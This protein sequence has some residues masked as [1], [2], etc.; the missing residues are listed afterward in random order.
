MK[1]FLAIILL[2]ISMQ[3]AAQAENRQSSL[4]CMQ[5][6][7]IVDS[8]FSY[9]S[10]GKTKQQM[11]APLPSKDVLAGYP[12]SMSAQRLLGEQM[13]EVVADIYSY[14]A[15]PKVAYSAY[16]AESCHRSTTG[17]PVVKDFSK[18]TAQLSHCGSLDR[19]AQYKC[20]FELAKPVL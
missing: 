13:L 5:L 19:E 8:A 7:Q 12:K 4:V 6:I 3:G 2:V 17:Q 20:G 18:V 14:E 1:Y 15:L 10:Q 16:R 9:K 11:L